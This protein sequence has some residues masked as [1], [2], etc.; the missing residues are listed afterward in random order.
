MAAFVC[1][2]Q[3]ILDV[4]GMSHTHL[5]WRVAVAEMQSDLLAHP[6]R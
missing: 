2:Q 5:Q 4:P 3:L 1:C 6:Y